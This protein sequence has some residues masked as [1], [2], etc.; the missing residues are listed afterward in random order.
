M[1][2]T[3]RD[4]ANTVHDLNHHLCQIRNNSRCMYLGSLILC[5]RLF[6]GVMCW[7]QCIVTSIKLRTVGSG[8]ASDSYATQLENVSSI[9]RTSVDNNEVQLSVMWLHPQSLH[10]Q[11]SSNITF[12]LSHTRCPFE[13]AQRTN[14]ESFKPGD[15]VLVLQCKPEPHPG[16]WLPATVLQIQH[17]DSRAEVK[18]T[19]ISHSNTISVIV[20]LSSL[21][22]A[23]K[24]ICTSGKSPF[25]PILHRESDN[26]VYG[27]GQGEDSD[28]VEEDNNVHA[29]IRSLPSYS[30]QHVSNCII[31]NHSNNSS[32]ANL[33][34]IYNGAGGPSKVPVG[35]W[36]QHTKGIVHTYILC[37][38]NS[39]CC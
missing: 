2:Q 27:R 32:S 30:Q 21:R 11:T 26:G 12:P 7:D 3:V 20:P 6:R 33:S 25:D 36:E 34:G 9:D 14:V 19:G 1:L 28:S 15:C 18:Y 8:G 17:G 38:A 24:P 16:I 13:T 4:L 22:M 39:L 23:P 35:M 5:P 31:S 29:G 10:E 37:M